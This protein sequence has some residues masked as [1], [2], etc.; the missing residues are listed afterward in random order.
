M[1]TSAL[2]RS[3]R[4]SGHA[5]STRADGPVGPLRIA[6]AAD[7]R[8]EL[9]RAAGGDPAA[10]AVP[11]QVHGA[12]VG[13]ADA[14]SSHAATDALVTATPG[15][16]LF[17]QGADCPLLALFDERARV[18][19][20]IHSG[21]RGT[22]ARV[23]AAAVATMCE[24]GA[25]PDRLVAAV[26]PGIGACCFEVG[27]EVA[28]AF[29]AEFGA[30]SQSWFGPGVREDRLQCDVRAAIVATLLG[31]GVG[32]GRIDVVPGCTACG[33]DY[34]SHRASRGAPERH[35]LCLVLLDGERVA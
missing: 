17:V 5:H 16:P 4:G 18:G 1:I 33:G 6:G 32:T 31:C 21:W 29:G 22:V 27:P 34:F 26:F 3:A 9:V 7:G 19:A 20:V 14:A 24:L 12:N 8:A 28:A 13:V 25:S 30:R 10:I 11:E 35:G 23:S 2:L 15:V